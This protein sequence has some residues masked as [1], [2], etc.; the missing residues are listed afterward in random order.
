MDNPL[1]Q[2]SDDALDRLLSGESAGAPADASVA[3]YRAVNAVLRVLQS[4]DSVEPPASVKAAAKR[5]FDRA[6]ARASIAQS[7][8]ELV[9]NLIF[10]S[11]SGAA[12]AGYRGQAASTHLVYSS[13][14]GEVDVR[15]EPD[16]KGA[17]GA[18][19]VTGFLDADAMAPVMGRA[20]PIGAGGMEVPI[21]A[22]T[23]GHFALRLLP[24]PYRLE[25]D[26]GGMRLLIPRLEV[27]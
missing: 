14:A 9:A 5:I 3:A 23:G 7:V 19:L 26:L 6:P 16:P 13:E 22:E 11:R 4:D 1:A 12:V 2:L 15:I 25:F 18:R 21:R 17:D 20:L 10:E 8:R 24:G 27:S